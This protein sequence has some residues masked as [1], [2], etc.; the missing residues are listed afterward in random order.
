MNEERFKEKIEHTI[1][2][3]KNAFRGRPDNFLTEGD[4]HAYAYHSFYNQPFFSNYKSKF[5]LVHHEYPTFSLV[6]FM[7]GSFDIGILNPKYAEPKW[8]NNLR[9]KKYPKMELIAKKDNVL[10]TAI[11]FKFIQKK[12]HGIME[13]I[14]NDT[15]KL[16]NQKGIWLKYVLVFDN[17]NLDLDFEELKQKYP[18]VFIKYIQRGKK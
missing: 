3:L 11:E 9:N 6:N 17:L 10:L 18:N 14:K 4:L 15:Q 7:R 13:D 16:N 1:N 5:T 2:T 8:I 12:N